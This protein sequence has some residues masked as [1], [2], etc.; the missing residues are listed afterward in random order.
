MS[1]ELFFEEDGVKKDAPLWDEIEERSDFLSI[2]KANAAAMLTAGLGKEQ[3]RLLYGNQ[4][5][6]EVQSKRKPKEEVSPEDQLER[7]RKQK[8]TERK[9]DGE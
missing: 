5:L 1:N 2:R 8:P 9:D 6:D 7:A 4:A 3:V